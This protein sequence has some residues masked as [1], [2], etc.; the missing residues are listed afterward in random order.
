MARE[1]GSDFDNWFTTYDGPDDEWDWED[2]EDEEDE[3]DK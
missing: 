1:L 2:E 3:E